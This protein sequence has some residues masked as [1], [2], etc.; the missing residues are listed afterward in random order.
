MNIQFPGPAIPMQDGGV[1]FR[2]FVDGVTVACW[3][4]WEALQ[5]VDPGLTQETP[6]NQFLASQDR[7]LDIAKEKILQ[8]Q[9]TNGVVH[10]SKDDV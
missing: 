2:A 10:I 8:G 9:V 1:S 5:D 6:L 7:L 4:T 3:F